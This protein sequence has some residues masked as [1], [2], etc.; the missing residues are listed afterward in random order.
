MKKTSIAYFVIFT[1]LISSIAIAQPSMQEPSETE[2]ISNRT[3][4]LLDNQNDYTGSPYYYVDFLKGSVLSKGKTIA[5]NQI[6]RYNVSKEEFEIR[7]SRN[8]ESKILKTILRNKDITIQIGDESFEY[9]SSEKN[10]LRGYFI[11]LFKGD[12]N[13]LYKKLKKE[14]IASQKAV[15][16]MA[17]DV[18]ALYKEK[19]IL[20]LV[21]DKGIYTE[22]ASSKKGKLKAFGDKKKKVKDYAKQNKLNLNKEKDLIK[23]V[24]YVNSL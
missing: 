5:S 11:P 17:S 1:L 18:A 2:Y 24:T 12:K 6:L 13:S 3:V 23:V 16:S 8:Q 20:Y 21:D 10:R 9:I 7:D 4:N 14:Y 19:E 15:S 22:L